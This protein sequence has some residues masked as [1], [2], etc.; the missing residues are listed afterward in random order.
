MKEIRFDIQIDK[1]CKPNYWLTVDEEK[2]KGFYDL[3]ILCDY[4]GKKLYELTEE[5]R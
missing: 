3:E 2:L 4:I 1:T 5:T